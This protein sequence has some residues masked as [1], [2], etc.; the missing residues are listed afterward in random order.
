MSGP[1]SYTPPPRYSINVFSGKLNQL[2]LLQTRLKQLVAEL[3][4]CNT[5]D[6]NLDIAFDCSEQLGKIRNQINIALKN[7]VFDYKGEF[8]QDVY[9]KIE[10]ELNEKISALSELFNECDQIK[11]EYTVK[12]SNYDSYLNYISFYE[13]SKQS[14]L[15]FKD[16]ILAYVKA[17][18]ADSN[19]SL[20]KEAENQLQAILFSVTKVNFKQEFNSEIDFEKKIIIDHI[21]KNEDLINNIRIKLSDKIISLNPDSGLNTKLSTTK[22]ESSDEI[23][24]IVK[25]IN[26]LIE[27]CDDII[28]RKK[29]IYELKNLEESNIYKDGYFYKEFHD[30]VFEKENT[31][32]GKIYLAGILAN[33]NG[34]EVHVSLQEKQK[35]IISQCL[36][37]MESSHIEKAQLIEIGDFL[38]KFEAE[39]NHLKEE[40]EIKSKENLFLKTQLIHI[41]ENK[42]YEVMDDLEVIDFEK[43]DDFLLKIK[44]Q[45]NY[46]NVNFKEDGSL[47]YVFQIPEDK[48]ELSTD[49]LNMKLRQMHV[50]CSEFQSALQD[51]SKMGL[52]LNLVSEKPVEKDSIISI[53][54]R[55]KH[56]IKSHLNT[57]IQQD[58]TR[59]NYL[60]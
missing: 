5:R 7:I 14:F 26:I 59:K 50:S 36:R 49:Q 51:L 33:I 46:L 41:L 43:A 22:G 53:T 34:L 24:Q 54:N 13:N 38:M 27:D 37:L 48:D 40:E 12:K 60:N 21:N 11:Y 31:R 52:E 2:F 17:N 30:S 20:F 23:K 32:K 16:Q 1:K 25:K 39:N 9:N 55:H 4:C 18:V 35:L 29:I 58:Q 10:N 6:Q 45:E 56:K 57:T 19:P 47:R 28:Q 42:G 44:G 8:G 3:D 15:E